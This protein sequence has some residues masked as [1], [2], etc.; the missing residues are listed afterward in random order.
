MDSILPTQMVCDY[1]LDEMLEQHVWFWGGWKENR[2]ILCYGI[3][4]SY[5][6]LLHHSSFKKIS[7]SM[8]L[9]MLVVQI[10]SVEG[11]FSAAVTQFGSTLKIAMLLK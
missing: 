10:N 7:Q 11:L 9:V 4:T 2:D 6:L 8:L 5:F 1:I 3:L